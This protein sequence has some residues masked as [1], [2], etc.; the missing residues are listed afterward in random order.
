MFRRVII[1]ALS[2]GIAAPAFADGIRDSASAAVERAVAQQAVPS[3]A[4]SGSRVRRSHLWPGAILFAS[5]M[6]LATY[7]F[8]HTTDGDYVEPSDASK[9]SKTGLGIS[10]LA[11]AAGGGAL[12]LLGGRAATGSS[13]THAGPT[14]GIAKRVTW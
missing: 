4:A 12:M 14:V 2:L 7:G 9:L 5:G 8:L 10:G 6:V 1:L 11:V 3:Q 13:L